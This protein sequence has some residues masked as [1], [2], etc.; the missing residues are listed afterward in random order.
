MTDQ[1]KKA[2]IFS[3]YFSNNKEPCGTHLR[4]LSLK[5]VHRS[6]RWEKNSILINFEDQMLRFDQRTWINFLL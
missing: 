6:H 1:H 2:L 4:I 3:N 5:N